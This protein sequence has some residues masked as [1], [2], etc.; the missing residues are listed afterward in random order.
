MD[1]HDNALLTTISAAFPLAPRPYARLAS[2]LGLSEDEVIARV[3][4]LKSG[5]VI[6]RIGAAIDPRSLAWY[7]TLCAVEVPQDHIEE[8]ARIV[9]AFDEVTHNY[10][11]A[12][13]PNCWFT[14]IAP[15]KLRADEIVGAIRSALNLPVLELPA[16][17]VFKIGV[18]FS[19]ADD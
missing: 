3:R 5:G 7:S 13:V 19:L 10:V 16:T 6:R 11:R 17:R 2:E 9:N 4:N 8:Y 12:G 15:D 14:V 18:R 1:K